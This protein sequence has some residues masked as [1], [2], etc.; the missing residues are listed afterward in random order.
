MGDVTAIL[1]R[2]IQEARNASYEGRITLGTPIDNMKMVLHNTDDFGVG[3]LFCAGPG[4][5]AGYLNTPSNAVF[6]PGHEFGLKPEELDVG[7]ND[8]IWFQ[9]SDLARFYN[10]NVFFCG[11]Q[12]DVI[13]IAGNKVDIGDVAR[14]V[15][16]SAAFRTPPVV[17]YSHAL[18]KMVALYLN[19]EHIN[20]KQ[21][22]ASLGKKLPAYALPMLVSVAE[23]KYRP[24]S[25]KI[26][27]RT[28][29]AQFEDRLPSN[30]DTIEYDYSNMQH[31]DA[32]DLQ[33]L[34][35]LVGILKDQNI[36]A[37]SLEVL[38]A[39]NF[40]TAG[41]TSLNAVAFVARLKKFGM[42]ISM[43]D[44]LAAETLE[45]VFEQL[46]EAKS[47]AAS[48]TS[49]SSDSTPRWTV[50]PLSH[51]NAAT[52]WEIIAANMVDVQ[53]T[54]YMWNNA[55]NKAKARQ[56]CY[57]EMLLIMKSLEPILLCDPCIS[58]GVF[59]NDEM[60][61]VCCNFTSDDCPPDIPSNG[62]ITRFLGF[63]SEL[64]ESAVSRLQ[65]E[66]HKGVHM[67]NLLSVIDRKKLGNPAQHVKAM[68]FIEE[69]LVRVAQ[70]HKLDFVIT[71]NTS[72]VTRD[73]APLL[74]YEVEKVTNGFVEWQDEETGK[75]IV[76]KRD[77]DEDF[78]IQVS[79]KLIEA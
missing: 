49:S 21:I 42:V 52:A 36:T 51:I 40:F 46:I 20:L 47:H 56:D 41:G 10:G 50:K 64:E 35:N 37:S 16:S 33:V 60:I 26:D 17:I 71:T 8:Q 22:S 1:L 70:E 76:Q 34:Q 44:F 13:K 15:N 25:G 66:G 58:F 29:I 7:T 79:Y 3:E 6:S 63:L 19:T 74:G 30:N 77:Q 72:P 65:A 38:L 23:F 69:E 78:D 59:D 48:E 68:Y 5:A 73:I 2:T 67:E 11:R 12:D 62:P 61:G 45:D 54:L 31:L 18:T 28:M 53:P 75:P 55:P 43:E 32:K 24:A 4:L 9:T 39:S 27:K 14:A 57:N